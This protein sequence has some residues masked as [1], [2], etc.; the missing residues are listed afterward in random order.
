MSSNNGKI[1]ETTNT[2]QSKIERYKWVTDGGR[3]KFMELDKRMLNVD[4]T[5][6]RGATES[7]ILAIAAAWC[8]VACCCIAVARRKDGTF[9]VMDGQHRVLASLRRADITTLPCMVF[10]VDDVSQEADGFIKGNRNR[11]PMTAHQSFAADVVRGDE[12]AMAV[13]NV[14]GMLGLDVNSDPN[15][16]HKN[17][18][19]TTRSI[20]ILLRIA[21]EAG[22]E[23]L[24]KIVRASMEICTDRP[25]S[26]ILLAGL[27]VIDQRLDG[28]L[29]PR[30][31][32]RLAGI[33]P[34]ELEKKAKEY[35]TMC[36]SGGSTS[37]AKG[38][39]EIA[40]RGLQKK[41]EFKA[42]K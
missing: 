7:K 15:T 24:E 41:F 25:V 19:N 39:I 36:G 27:Y 30:L 5:Y 23:M 18:P 11:K 9:W 34:A 4:G 37:W 2:G 35:A 32:Q 28:G 13:S 8:W 16:V 10:D 20:G 12:A 29:S 14:C 1:T 26:Q 33:G 17:M 6:Q 40:N 22:A 21:R 3:G 31:I 42:K 38:M